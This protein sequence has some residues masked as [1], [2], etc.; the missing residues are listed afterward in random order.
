MAAALKT[1]I[2]QAMTHNGAPNSQVTTGVIKIK[3]IAV[4]FALRSILPSRC[5]LSING[6]KDRCSRNH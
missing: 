1:A 4:R 5:Q 6:P 3:T 2:W